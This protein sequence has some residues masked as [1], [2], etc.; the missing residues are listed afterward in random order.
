M[1]LNHLALIELAAPV[2]KPRLAALLSN[3]FAFLFVFAAVAACS[4]G[5]AAITFALIEK[6]FLS[7]RTRWLAGEW[8][9]KPVPAI[10]LPVPEPTIAPL[11]PYPTRQAAVG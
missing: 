1:Y 11:A 4:A 6:P 3:N 2:S 8:T 7:L 5:L 9:R 10:V